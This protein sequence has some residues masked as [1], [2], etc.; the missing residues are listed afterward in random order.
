MCDFNLQVFQTKMFLR[1]PRARIK[2]A[3]AGKSKEYRQLLRD[4]DMLNAAVAQI[5]GRY[6]MAC[7]YGNPVI[8][9]LEWLMANWEQILEIIMVIIDLFTKNGQLEPEGG[10]GEFVPDVSF[11]S[12]SGG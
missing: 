2:A 6:Y 5:L 12:G 7:G 11:D 4:E 8:D 3:K 10:D 1:G 9:L